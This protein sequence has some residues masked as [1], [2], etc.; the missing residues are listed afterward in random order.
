MA[1]FFA[2]GLARLVSYFNAGPPHTLFILLMVI[3]LVL[4]IILFLAY[5][6]WAVK[7]L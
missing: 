6:R 2:G 7:P 1:L 3:E 5:R 4:P